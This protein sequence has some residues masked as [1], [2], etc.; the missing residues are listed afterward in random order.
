VLA[1]SA[2]GPDAERIL[3]DEEKAAEELPRLLARM[4]DLLRQM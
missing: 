4:F 3:V 2:V 1:I